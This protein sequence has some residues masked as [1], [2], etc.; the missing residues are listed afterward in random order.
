MV[1]LTPPVVEEKL[2]T[3]VGDLENAEAMLAAARDEEVAAKHKF[4]A[5]QRRA[6]L[7]AD[8]P[9]IRRDGASAA[10][11]DAWVEEQCAEEMEA[12]DLAKVKRETAEDH[13]KTVRD[14]SFVVAGLAKSVNVRYG[15]AGRGES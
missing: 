3:L 10:E 11:R 1:D 14:Q 6:L 9:K 4:K 8:C 12:M 13:V 7:S 15:F 5:A 2:R